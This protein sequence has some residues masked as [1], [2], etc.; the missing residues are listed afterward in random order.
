MISALLS[1]VAS[2]T[3]WRGARCRRSSG[4]LDRHADPAVAD[5]G[6]CPDYVRWLWPIGAFSAVAGVLA[7]PALVGG[8]LVVRPRARMLVGAAV[9]GAVI[10]LAAPSPTGLDA[11]WTD[12]FDGGARTIA[13][14][15][16]RQ[17]GARLEGV[18]RCGSHGVL[19]VVGFA[20]VA[21]LGDF[22]VADPI[23]VR[24]FGERGDA[25]TPAK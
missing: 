13:S 12:G 17:A 16:A 24:Q 8:R 3:A 5:L 19:S 20:F 1:A 21:G 11:R 25:A 10:L 15:L 23:L 9:V 18:G 22:A 4:G 2:G 7:V 14:G 6:L